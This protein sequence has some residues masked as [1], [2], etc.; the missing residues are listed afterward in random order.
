MLYEVIT[1]QLSHTTIDDTLIQFEVWDAITKQTTNTTVFLKNSD[2][3]T[4][5]S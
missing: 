3:M 1:L 4:S 2:I 5:T